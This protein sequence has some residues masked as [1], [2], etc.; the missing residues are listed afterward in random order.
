MTLKDDQKSSNGKYDEIMADRKLFNKTVYTPLSEALRL[1]DERQ[2]DKELIK[3]IKELLNNDIPEPLKKIARYG[4]FGKQVA[5]PNHDAH[6]FIELT[7]SHNLKP[8]FYEYHNDKFTSNNDFKHSL[9]Q[10]N[11]HEDKNDRKGNRIE[12][13]ITI[14][15]FNKYDGKPIKEVLT[16]WDESLIDFHKRL[17]DICGYFKEDFIFYDSSDWLKRNGG[18]AENYYEKDLML[19]ICFGIL[20]EN[21][22]NSGEEGEFTKNV[23]LPAFEHVIKTTGLKP[24]IVPIPP[25]DN[26]EDTHWIS[27]DKKIKPF[28][29]LINSNKND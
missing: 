25:M 10:L 14:I 9:G 2:K 21:F 17:F 23:F 26:Q 27:Y 28:I 13:K 19:Y 18:K 16:L 15:D 1:L 4:I 7:K 12:E 22:L 6:W 20:F 24:L 8:V 29:K 3:K 11:L 5:T